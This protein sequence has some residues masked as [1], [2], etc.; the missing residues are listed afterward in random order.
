MN[1]TDYEKPNDDPVI[2]SEFNVKDPINSFIQVAKNVVVTP[3]EFF[4][5][6]PAEAE[7]QNPLI[8][9]AFCL[10]VSTLFLANIMGM[11]FP[12]FLAFFI[13]HFSV[14]FLESGLLYLAAKNFFGGKGSFSGTFRIIAYAGTTNLVSW[15][16]YLGI[17]ASF[18]GLYLVVVGIT[19]VHKIETRGAV[20]TLLSTIGFLFLITI[21]LVVMVGTENF[22]T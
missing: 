1:M 16:P 10:F 3:R 8:F 21:L 9:L 5:G 17:I 6:M 18:Y 12:A 22:T 11:N 2:I 19:Q 20:F 14:T 13:L 4:S 15:I 7:L